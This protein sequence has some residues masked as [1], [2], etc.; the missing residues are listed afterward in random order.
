MAQSFPASGSIVSARSRRLRT[1]GSLLVVA[2]LAMSV[3]G[4]TSLMP[5]LR[6]S[7]NENPVSLRR[8]A[9]RTPEQKARRNIIKAQIVFAYGYWGVCG[10]LVLSAAFVAYLDFREVSRNYMAQR[11]AIWSDIAEKKSE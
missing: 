1:I 2:V 6:R 11:R 4:V 3:Y 9:V 5:S 7:I 8:D 10:L